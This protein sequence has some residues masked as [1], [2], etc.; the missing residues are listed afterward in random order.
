MYNRNKKDYSAETNSLATY[1]KEIN[2]IPLL[3][4][5][6]E[7]KYAK[8]AEKGDEDAKNM[9]V[10]SNLRFVVNVAKK[11]QNQGLPLMD[12]ISEGNIG[13]INAAERFDVSK[14]YK[15]ISYAVWWIKQSI[16]KAICEKSRMIRLPLNRANELVQIEKAKKEIDF[17]GNETQELNEIA[18]ILNMNNSMVHT[19][20]NAAKEPISI[21]APVFDEPGSSSVNDFLQDETHQMPE[22]YA[23]DMSLRDEVNELLKN[24]DDREAEIIRLRFGLDGSAPLS[25]KE[26]GLIFNL[27]KERIRQIEKK[28]L[29]QLKNPAEKQKLAVYVA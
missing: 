19:I 14:G 18:G 6:E 8:L 20:M 1:L 29:Q 11:Y 16:L 9:L 12:L 21:D 25:L 3:T 28:A 17:A 26:V 13:L 7:I 5:E 10:N 27:T 22:D 4:A 15:F 23:L 2:K 24:L